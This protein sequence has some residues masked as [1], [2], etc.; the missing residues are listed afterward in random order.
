MRDVLRE[1]ETSV[2]QGE[3]GIKADST[4]HFL[5]AEAAGNEI[6]LRIMD[7]LM[8]LLRETRETSLQ[9]SGR[10]IRS[11]KQ[12]K[13]LLRAIETRDPAAAER[14]M[15]EHITEMEKLVFSTQEWPVGSTADTAQGPLPSKVG[16]SA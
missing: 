15:R 7:S 2:R 1:Q 12:H 8:D 11:L 14:H 5:M 10:S 3:T 9:A 13:A 6:L 16:E 4:F